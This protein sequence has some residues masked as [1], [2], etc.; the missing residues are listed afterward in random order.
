ME[1]NSARVKLPVLNGESETR[2]LTQP[3][4]TGAA[5]L[6]ELSFMQLCKL[7]LAFTLPLLLAILALAFGLLARK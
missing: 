1:W 3:T 7:G 4:A 2:L 5:A 6:A